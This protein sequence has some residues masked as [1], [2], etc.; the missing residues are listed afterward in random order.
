MG[1]V[2]GNSGVVKA[3]SNTVAN[4]KSWSFTQQIDTASDTSMGATDDTHK[5]GIKSGSGSI[6]CLY[7]ASDTTGQ[8]T[9]T[10]GASVTLTLNNEGVVTATK[11]RTFT[12]TITKIDE[13]Q[14]DGAIVTRNFDYKIN[15]AVTRGTNP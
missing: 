15:G 11:N 3:G 13:G 9:L 1:T 4:I 2:H 5:T 14:S 12:A 6:N 8:E 10:V 7:N